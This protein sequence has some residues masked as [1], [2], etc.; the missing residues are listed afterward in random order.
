MQGFFSTFTS[1]LQRTGLTDDVDLRYVFD[2]G[3]D[4]GHFEGSA[5]VTV[6][7]VP[8]KA[9]QRL[10]KR[11]R[12]F[13]FSPFG[14][15]ALRKLLEYHIVPGAVVHS[16]YFHNQTAE[17]EPD[18][19]KHGTKFCTCGES[20]L[21]KKKKKKKHPHRE[22]I[23][24]TELDLDTRFFNHSIHWVAEKSELT[25]PGKKGH[26][27]LDT[28]VFVNGRKVAIPDI[29]AVNGAVHVLDR[30]MCPWQHDGDGGHHHHGEHGE[31]RH[32]ML[33]RYHGHH[34]GSAADYVHKLWDDQEDDIWKGWEERLPRFVAGH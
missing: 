9:F 16:D 31:A 19:L 18:G 34:D 23:S 4:E 30:I 27:E 33:N 7:A 12:L 32:G 14:A 15:S 5:V 29:I 25:F 22:P 24:S 8:D 6:F 21:L 1:A 28:E 17:T 20:E 3:K 11:L 26:T 2:E 10:P 13:L